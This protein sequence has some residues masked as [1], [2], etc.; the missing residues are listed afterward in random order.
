MSPPEAGQVLSKGPRPW[1]SLQSTVG[2]LCHSQPGGCIS[3][4]YIPGHLG[5]SPEGQPFLGF[6][7]PKGPGVEQKSSPLQLCPSPDQGVCTIVCAS[8]HRPNV[9]Q[10]GSC[11]QGRPL[12]AETQ[13]KS[14]C[15]CILSAVA[16][17]WD[18]ARTGRVCVLAG[19]ASCADSEGIWMLKQG[20]FRGGNSS[21]RGSLLEAAQWER[22]RPAG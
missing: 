3:G 13:D 9:T 17:A 16:G 1:Q 2:S 15:T 21:W 5:Q 12:N 7:S 8:V 22:R 14:N 10:T 19:G 18:P 4:I 20:V 6:S 11:S